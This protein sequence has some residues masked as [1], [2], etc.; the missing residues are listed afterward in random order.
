MI[1]Q[2]PACL[3][4]F[5]LRKEK[6]V[7]RDEILCPECGAMLSLVSKDPLRF[8]EVDLADATQET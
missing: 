6:I 1:T 2:C 5:D 4:S 8:T 7:L 3:R